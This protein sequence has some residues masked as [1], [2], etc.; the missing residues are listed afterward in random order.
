MHLLSHKNVILR[1][2]SSSE[3]AEQIDILKDF[4]SSYVVP[5]YETLIKDE[6][7]SG[8]QEIMLADLEETKKEL[9]TAILEKEKNLRF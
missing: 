8:L 6:R 9:A 5:R 4:I 1:W 3:T 7:G 2:L